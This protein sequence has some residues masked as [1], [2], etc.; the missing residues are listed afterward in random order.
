MTIE[1]YDMRFS[2]YLSYGY[3]FASFNYIECLSSHMNH[4]CVPNQMLEQLVQV[5]GRLLGIPRLLF[6]L[7]VDKCATEAIRIASSPF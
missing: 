5:I 2:G 3:L 4:L 1:P 6:G 7:K